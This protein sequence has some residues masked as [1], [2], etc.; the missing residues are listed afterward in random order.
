MLL[1][2]FQGLAPGDWIRC[3]CRCRPSLCDNVVMGRDSW[4]LCFLSARIFCDI[5]SKCH[6]RA[7]STADQQTHDSTL[8]CALILVP[9]LPSLSPPFLPPTYP[10][11]SWFSL[12]ST[13]YHCLCSHLYML[14][15]I[16]I[17]SSHTNVFALVFS[18]IFKCLCML[19][20]A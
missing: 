13:L 6:S 17:F 4:Q 1:W 11:L 10:N 19:N 16:L 5:N 3:R 15:C 2:A 9:F 14:V 12:L 7:V 20:E 18:R 8:M